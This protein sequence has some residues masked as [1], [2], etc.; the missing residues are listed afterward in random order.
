MAFRSSPRWK[1]PS[2]RLDLTKKPSF[3]PVSTPASR[4]GT[5][6]PQLSTER[7]LP[8]IS[9]SCASSVYL[10]Y[11][12]LVWWGSPQNLPNKSPQGMP[13]FSSGRVFLDISIN[14]IACCLLTDLW[15]YVCPDIFLLIKYLRGIVNPTAHPLPGGAKRSEM[16]GTYPDATNTQVAHEPFYGWLLNKPIKPFLSLFPHSRGTWESA[17]NTQ[18]FHFGLCLQQLS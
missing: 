5:L 1:L 18:G 12:F 17:G 14:K 8:F 4:E 2:R 3:V 16:A 9:S 13:L 7:A 11:N 15:S 6:G 10:Q